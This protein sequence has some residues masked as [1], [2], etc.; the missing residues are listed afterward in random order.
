[1]YI[2]ALSVLACPHCRAPFTLSCTALQRDEFIDLHKRAKVSSIL[3]RA[4]WKRILKSCI[5]GKISVPEK[6]ALHDSDVIDPE[7]LTDDEVDQF[8]EL[9]F[10]QAVVEGE[11]ICNGCSKAYEIRNRIPRLTLLS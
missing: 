7:T 3:S 9:L 8:Y 11:L 10:L 6:Y 1:M 2:S 4:C 5:A